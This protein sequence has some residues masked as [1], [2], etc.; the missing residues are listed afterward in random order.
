MESAY[1][2]ACHVQRSLLISRRQF[3]RRTRWAPALFL[4]APLCAG[5]RS[6]F[7]TPFF[8]PGLPLFSEG[9]INPHYPAVSPVEEVIRL[10]QPGADSYLTEKYAAEI[11]VVL[12]QWRDRIL[13]G[14]DWVDLAGESV[15][16]GAE[17]NV[18]EKIHEAKRVLPNGVEVSR[19]AFS[20]PTQLDRE[21]L[22]VGLKK[23]LSNPGNART[24]EFEIVGVKQLSSQ[25]L[26][27][28]TQVRYAIVYAR[29]TG[30]REERIGFWNLVW[31]Q[32]GRGNWNIDK[33]RF[34]M[35]NT[36][37]S[38]SA[39]FKD[40]SPSLLGDCESYKNQLLRGTDYWRTVLDGASGMG[41]YGNNG[42]AAGDFDNDGFDDLYVCQ[43]SGLPNRL[44][45]NRGDGTFEDVTEKSGVGVLDPTACALFAD[46]QNRGLQDLLVVCDSGPLLFLNRGKGQFSLKRDAFSFATPPQGT[47][48]HAAVADYDRDGRLDV[49]FCLYAYY[50]GLD[51]YHY[52]SPY[53]D[54]RNGPA[55]FLFHNEG[56][57]K[58]VDHT[59]D[60]GLDEE[61]DRFS[62]ACAWGDMNGNGW[63]DLYV[64][65]DFGRSNLYR[66]DGNGRFTAVSDS[67]GANDVGAGM[68]ACWLDVENDGK[69]DIYVSNM[70]SAAGLRIS[71]QENFHPTDSQEIRSFY[72]RHAAGN[73]LY[74][75]LGNEQFKNVAALAK[76]EMGRWAWSSDSWDFDHDGYSDLYVANG[77]ISGI[78]AKELSSFFWRQ[79][80]GNSPAT[81]TPSASYE[82]GWNAINELIR[83]DHSWSGYERNTLLSNNHDGTFSDMSGISG[84]DFPDDSRA[85]ALA[86]LNHD[87][88][89]EIILKN[90]TAPQLRILQNVMPGI[91]DSICFRLLGTK[92]N[93]DAI[94]TSVT[95]RSADLLQTKYLQ[96][97]T[98]F[99]SQHT[100]E[101]FFGLGKSS[102]PISAT[103]R[104]PN[105]LMQNFENIPANQRISIEEGQ[106]K[107]SAVPFPSGANS[108]KTPQSSL[109]E[110]FPAATATWLLDPL[111]APEFSLSDSSGLAQ[112]LVSFRG[113]PLLLNFWS[114]NIA[115]AL[116]QLKA[117]QR[118]QNEFSAKHLRIAC[119]NL[120]ETFTASQLVALAAK[121]NL[122]LPLLLGSSEVA[123]V[124]NI[125]YR[126][127]FDRRRDLSLPTSFLLDE[128]SNIVKIYQG[129]TDPRQILADSANIPR[130]YEARVYKAL[131]FPGVLHNGRFQR[132]AFTYGVALFQ[133]GYLDQ[134]AASFKQVAAAQP[135]NA[136]AFYNL[137][138]LYLRKNNI[139]EARNF[140]KQTVELKPDYPEAW[141]NLG[142]IAVQQNDAVTAIDNFRRSL[143]FR[144]NYVTAMLNLGNVFRRQG[145]LYEAGKLLNQAVQ[146]EPE[147]AEANYS[148]G[149]FFA[150][151]G[152]NGNAE[153][154]LQKA[155]A[156]RSNYAEAINNLGV[157]FIR[158]G[159]NAEAEQQFKHCISVAPSFDQAYLNLAQ[160]Y[161][162]EK[163]NDKAR[164]ILEALLKLQPQHKLARQALEMLH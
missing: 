152:D 60:S 147:N 64:A 59:R 157:L 91:G 78:E 23:E 15:G 39:F 72:R 116:N 148:L 159:K 48:T 67:S 135:E 24:A 1:S 96:A 138:T 142:M 8:H 5:L 53:F 154:L 119:I 77:Y 163:Q 124:Y 134:A 118:A 22:L 16:S 30:S 35:E 3:L 97:G 38:K 99:L 95:V 150:R 50:L 17:S 40:V 132:N 32:N 57:S 144:P 111:P 31:T 140:L 137:G 47:F 52:P 43:P 19:R 26:S 6:G 145:N 122:S 86:D 131:P 87:G 46:F 82:R 155:A 13:A 2:S 129:P 125:I 92:S 158:D 115:A 110:Q 14:G 73:S 80:A 34:L 81:N 61:N 54:A 153:P 45:R 65:N 75:N 74:K 88:R 103:V 143:E 37:F 117:F 76:A 162:I 100:K 112:T 160:L 120:D 36:S 104:W 90:R 9:Q 85:F 33:W 62:F 149:M 84:L 141:N 56:N 29:E 25:P 151:Q 105:G 123:G 69:Q 89:L 130:T 161:A 114:V 93:R 136:E 113:K 18:L 63:P 101:L 20:P 133:H 156:L 49:Y 41:V 66:N 4:P 94:G 21:R 27:V 146:L 71:T 106:P 28:E 109:P 11:H 12:K 121:E 164:A 79:V 7:A 102:G 58:F 83:S 68:S 128:S 42:V 126:Y 55:N 108:P 107:F 139:D 70:W 98:G 51:Q 10:V 44:Y 127:L